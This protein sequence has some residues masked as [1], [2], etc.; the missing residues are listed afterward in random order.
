M[1]HFYAFKLLSEYSEKELQNFYPV[2][3]HSFQKARHKDSLNYVGVEFSEKLDGDVDPRNSKRLKELIDLGWSIF[4]TA[5]KA[6]Q[7]LDHETE[8]DKYTPTELELAP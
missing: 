1:K 8:A 4:E 3:P 5:A 7:F 2:N 6:A